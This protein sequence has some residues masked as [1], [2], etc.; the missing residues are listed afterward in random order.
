MVGTTS[1]PI[2]R[3]SG[4]A[5]LVLVLASFQMVAN[6][7]ESRSFVVWDF[8]VVPHPAPIAGL[9]RADGVQAELKMSDAQKKEDAAILERARQKYQQLRQEFKD[10]AKFR[11]AQDAYEKERR[12]AM[13]ANLTEDQRERLEQ[14]QLRAEGR[15]RLTRVTSH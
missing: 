5:V 1:K 13:L 15:R 6:A 11:E 10:A 4:L 3:L 2:A 9:L 14:I 8:G 12:S 7:Q